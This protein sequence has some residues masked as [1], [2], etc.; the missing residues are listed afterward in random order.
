MDRADERVVVRPT[1]QTT[2]QTTSRQRVVRPDRTT[3]PAIGAAWLTYA[4]AGE[5]FGM[6]P[7]A[8]RQRARRM[9]WR[10]QPGNDGPTLVLVPDS[11]AVM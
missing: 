11:T 3:G 6:S 10:T 7:E 4:Q 2:G 9:R 8:A 1:G 5:R